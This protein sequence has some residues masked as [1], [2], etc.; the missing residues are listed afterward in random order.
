MSFQWIVQ[1]ALVEA[2]DAKLDGNRLFG[3]GQ[4]EE[5]LVRYEV[6]LQVAPEMSSSVEIRSICHANRA[7][8]FF[9][10]SSNLMFVIVEVWINSALVSFDGQMIIFFLKF[11]EEA[12][13]VEEQLG[14]L[15]E[16]KNAELCYDV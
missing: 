1:K 6:A 14:L 7:I 16:D 10:L 3:D 15:E 9:K 13:K 2:N 8:C 12:D 11:N 5:A 4:Y